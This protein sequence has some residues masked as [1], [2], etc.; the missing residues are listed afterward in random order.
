MARR[1]FR[2]AALVAILV[3]AVATDAAAKVLLT[4]DEA[5]RLALGDAASVDRRTA[6]LTDAQVVR[7]RAIAGPGIEIRSALVVWYEAKS[8]PARRAYFDTHRV[9]TLQ[10]TVLLV[11]EPDETIG[12]IEVLS[13][14]EP[15]E[16]LP[17]KT[18]LSQFLGKR[19]DAELDTR[20]G[21]RGITGATLSSSAVTEAARRVLAVDRVLHE[22]S[23][24]GT[25]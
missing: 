8:G 2:P 9:R 1:P 4:Q 24:P 12:R 11:V 22:A 10:E 16:Y 6:F 19:L 15:P 21:I 7:A 23:G 5:L 20:R 25:P 17:R 13:F 14:G 3:L 18:F